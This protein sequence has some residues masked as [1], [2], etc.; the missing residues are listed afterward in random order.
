MS[1]DTNPEMFDLHDTAT[2]RTT[3]VSKAR[4]RSTLTAVAGIGAAF[5]LGAAGLTYAATATGGATLADDSTAQTQWQDPSAQDGGQSDQLPQ[6]IPPRTEGQD[7]T[8]TSAV[9]ATAEQERGL[10]YI[11]TVVGYDQGQAAGTG[12]VL[13]S[14]GTI[15]TNHHVVEGA[16]TIEVEVISTGRTYEADLVGYDSSADV[17]VLQ[18][19]GV[20]GLDT[21]DLDESGDVQVGDEITAVG[22]A[23]GDG[24]AASASPGTVTALEQ[25]ITAQ[26]ESGSEELTGL[27]QVDADVISGDSGGA[28][29][30]DDGEVIGMTTAASSGSADITGYAVPIEDAIAIVG[31]IE[32]GQE[33]GGV[34]VGGSAFLG[35]QMSS[36]STQPTVVG[37]VDGSPAAAAGITE[38]STIIAVDGTGVSTADE[39]SSLIATHDP[40]DAISVIWADAQG[41]QHT[42]SVTLTTG[43]VG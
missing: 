13:T 12:M 43:P 42:A 29:Y 15:L 9:D 2:T 17:A 7:T 37:T 22:N 33:S 14:S 1:H 4:H 32:S 18:L 27:I 8:A 23:N 36:Q 3:Y 11:N 20:S 40:G 6:L 16:T 31:Q 19:Q 10:V 24:G 38:G 5:A 41:Q 30:D 34:S 25:Q 26:A 28:L 35:I 21:V 39:V